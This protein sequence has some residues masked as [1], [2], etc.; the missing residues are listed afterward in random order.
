MRGTAGQGADFRR[1]DRAGAELAP[2]WLALGGTLAVAVVIA[3]TVHIW[4]CVLDFRQFQPEP[5][6]SAGPSITC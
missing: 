6:L 1:R 4:A 3:A 5:D 2:M